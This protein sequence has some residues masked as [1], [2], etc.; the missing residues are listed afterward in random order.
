MFVDDPL[1][2]RR[3][4]RI[5]WAA[6]NAAVDGFSQL[7]KRGA[8]V[9]EKFHNGGADGFRSIED[10]LDDGAKISAERTSART[11]IAASERYPMAAQ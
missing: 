11:Q 1:R 9:L 5:I 4:R 10:T 2:R 8:D 3:G 7:R 6:K